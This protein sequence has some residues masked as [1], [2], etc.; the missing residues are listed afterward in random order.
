M[1]LVR[2]SIFHRAFQFCRRTSDLRIAVLAR[3]GFNREQPAPMNIFEIAIRKLVS[4]LRILGE[5]SV[6]A[7]MPFRVFGEPV[8]A[9]EFVL[10]IR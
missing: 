6:D 2:D 4:L 5:A 10:F 9:Y 8:Q 3:S 7:E 1:S